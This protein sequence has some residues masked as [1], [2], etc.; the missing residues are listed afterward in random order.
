[1]PT[2]HL[3]GRTYNVIYKYIFALSITQQQQHHQR[4]G[5]NITWQ[6]V[7]NLKNEFI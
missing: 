7:M 2:H 4:K 3:E 1:M 6:N 5:Q